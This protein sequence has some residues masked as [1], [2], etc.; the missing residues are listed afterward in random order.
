[1]LQLTAL[2]VPQD[3]VLEPFPKLG[4]FQEPVPRILQN[5]GFLELVPRTGSGP[6]VILFMEEIIWEISISC[7]E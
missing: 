6:S 3:L 5:I 1:V 7:K 4:F 2:S